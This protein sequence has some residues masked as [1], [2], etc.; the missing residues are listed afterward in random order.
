MSL[1]E[2]TGYVDGEHRLSAEL[3]PGI[4]PGP[5]KILVKLPGEETEEDPESWARAVAKA[6]MADWSDPR[7]DIYT[8][9]DGEPVDGAK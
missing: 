8:L 2:V 1:I 4:P 7:E 9:D 5:V 6:W 3:P